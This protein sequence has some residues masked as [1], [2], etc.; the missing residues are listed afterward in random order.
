[1]KNIR[2]MYV[3]Q[4][5]RMHRNEGI[6]K[7]AWV[8]FLFYGKTLTKETFIFYAKSTFFHFSV[9]PERSILKQD[10]AIW[11]HERYCEDLRKSLN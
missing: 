7:T 11:H 9:N 2:D 5:L 1:M 4:I 6:R 3:K 8:V 10:G